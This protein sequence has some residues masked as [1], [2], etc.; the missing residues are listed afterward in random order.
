MSESMRIQ[1]LEDREAIR[2]LLARY[3]YLIARGDVD[4]V[5]DLF[6]SDCRVEI[7][8]QVY[9]G[10]AGLRTLYASALDFSPKPYIHNHL[11]EELD[12]RTASSSCVLEIR[13]VRDGE[14]ETGGGC[15]EDRYLKEDGTWK[16]SER[17]FR[18]Y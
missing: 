6:T 5:I 14:P 9:E 12:V 1:Q 3:C 15:Y 10:A 18:V 11:I 16:F 8:G 17:R 4:A 13:Q 2:D 7:L